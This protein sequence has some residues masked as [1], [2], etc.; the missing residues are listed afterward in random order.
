V[1]NDVERDYFCWGAAFFGPVIRPHQKVKK[2]ESYG[3]VL[4]ELRVIQDS[5]KLNEVAPSDRFLIN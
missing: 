4:L 3:M 2:L 1:G 5:L